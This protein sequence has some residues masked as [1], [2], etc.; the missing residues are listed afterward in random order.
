MTF[1]LKRLRGV[2]EGHL[3]EM[4][5]KCDPR[6][7]E[8]CRSNPQLAS[9]QRSLN[10]IAAQKVARLQSGLSFPVG[11]EIP[12]SV[13]IESQFGSKPSAMYADVGA[14]RCIAGKRRARSPL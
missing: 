2:W 6:W 4:Q 11:T 7:D 9:G 13:I 3:D 14:M 10:L 12:Q 5:M 8:I 1:Q